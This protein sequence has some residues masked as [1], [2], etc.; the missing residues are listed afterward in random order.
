MD[1]I[2]EAE[3]PEFRCMPLVEVVVV[4]LKEV[5]VRWVFV[6]AELKY[7]MKCLDH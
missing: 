2:R 1:E 7:G 6:V 3:T 5:E 4:E